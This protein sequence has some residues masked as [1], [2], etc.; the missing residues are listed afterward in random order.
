LPE[1]SDD[2]PLR[3]ASDL[4]PVRVTPSTMESALRCGLRWLLEKHGGSLPA[5][6]A[7]GVGQSCPCRRDVR[8]R[9]RRRSATPTGYVDA[10][11]D[12][13]ELAARWLSGR[14]KE[15]AEG[16]VDKLI[17]WLAENPRRL[18]AV[19]REFSVR[20]EGQPPI[21]LTGRVDRLE[22]DDQGRLVVI[23]LKT[24]KTTTATAAALPEH[25]QLGA[26]QVAV[27]EGAFAEGDVSGGA[28]W[29]SL[30]RLT[31]R[32]RSRI[33][34]RCATAK[35]RAGRTRWCTAPPTPWPPPPLWPRPTTVAG[36]ARSARAAR[37]RAR[38]GRWWHMTQLDLFHTRSPRARAGRRRSWPAASGCNPPTPEQAAV[39]G[40]PVA[41]LL[42][43][44][45]AGSGK[46]ETMAARV[47]WLVANGHVPR[48]GAG[49][50]LHP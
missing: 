5:T 44:A 49:P 39:I 47:L 45:G 16:M 36:C 3:D 2:R 35:I 50:D 17:R 38:A 29:S 32:P 26:Y 42:V 28:A 14:E 34:R 37:C 1:L 21:E 40:A 41:P 48:A 19:E 30:A 10:R 23:D 4:E 7:Q 43:V 18:I 33:R 15:R 9:G 13:I 20:L 25:P 11:F 46:T 22:V 6:G 8:R 31:R 12:A 24:G 27:E